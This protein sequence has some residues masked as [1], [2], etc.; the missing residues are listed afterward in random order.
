[1][2]PFVPACSSEEL[3]IRTYPWVVLVQVLEDW[4]LGLNATES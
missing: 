3:Q 1:M 2:G 4:L